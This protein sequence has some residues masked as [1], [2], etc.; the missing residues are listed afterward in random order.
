M[1]YLIHH[2][3]LMTAAVGTRHREKRQLILFER[4]YLIYANRNKLRVPRRMAAHV[5]RMPSDV[6]PLR[7]LAQYRWALIERRFKTAGKEPSG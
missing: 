4:L 6:S 7:G 5:A 1:D 3:H 2:V